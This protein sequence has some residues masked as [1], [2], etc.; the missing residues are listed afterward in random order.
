MELSHFAMIFLEPD[1]LHASQ[2]GGKGAALARLGELGFEIPE[3]FAITPDAIW[4]PSQ[5][6][7]AVAAL[8]AGLFAVRSSGTMEEGAGHSFA[9][10]FESFLEISASDVAAKIAAARPH[11]TI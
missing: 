11:R 4:T 5:L 1:S 8:G 6:E 9:G 2:L 10:Q 3:W 7:N